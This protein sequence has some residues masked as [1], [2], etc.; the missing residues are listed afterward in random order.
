MRRHLHQLFHTSVWLLVVTGLW[1]GVQAILPFDWLA[2]H[3]AYDTLLPLDTQLAGAHALLPIAC[4][5]EEPLID[6][7]LNIVYQQGLQV[8]AYAGSLYFVFAL[9]TIVVA[10]LPR[11]QRLAPL[12]SLCNATLAVWSCQWVSLCLLREQ[13]GGLR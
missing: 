13:L 11:R 1:S 3:V 7:G 4:F 2:A 8:F 6:R 12:L 9:A 5:S 10:L